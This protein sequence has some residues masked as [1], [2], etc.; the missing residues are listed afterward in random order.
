VVLARI[1]AAWNDSVPGRFLFT[2]LW[3]RNS[4]PGRTRCREKAETSVLAAEGPE[5]E[6]VL[7]IAPGTFT[8]RATVEAA[9]QGARHAQHRRAKRLCNDGGGDSTRPQRGP[10]TVARVAAIGDN[11]NVNPDTPPES[12][13]RSEIQYLLNGVTAQQVSEADSLREEARQ[14]LAELQELWLRDKR[15][16]KIWGN[17]GFPSATNT[18]RPRKSG[19][20]SRVQSAEDLPRRVHRSGRPALAGLAVVCREH[21]PKRP[22]AFSGRALYCF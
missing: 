14:I 8:V 13:T 21:L 2:I 9:P 12:L 6:N 17:R 7:R 18:F 15:G 20:A 10:L 1:E 11:L 3:T 16:E 4:Q 22:G 5:V 19:R